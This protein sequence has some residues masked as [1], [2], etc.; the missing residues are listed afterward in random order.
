[1]NFGLTAKQARV[2]GFI[3]ERL[4][5][6]GPAPSLSEIARATGLKRRH[7]AHAIVCALKAR[8]YVD[9]IPN[10]PRSLRLLP[11]IPDSPRLPEETGRALAAHCACTGDEPADVIADAVALHLDELEGRTG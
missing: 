3:A 8:G 11:A 6:G 10:T 7:Q 5:A 1:M 2:L 4:D 9:W